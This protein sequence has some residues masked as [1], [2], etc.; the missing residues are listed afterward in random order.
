MFDSPPRILEDP[1]AVPLIGPQGISFIRETADQWQSPGARALRSHVVLRSRFAEDRLAVAAQRGVRQYIVLGAGF[2]TFA[3]RQP[4]WASALQIVEIDHAGTQS[5]KHSMLQAAGIAIPPNV[6]LVS[7]DFEH[8]TLRD[9]LRRHA[10]SHE[11]P[12]FVSWLGVTMYLTEAAIDGVLGTI[13]RFPPGSEVVLTFAPKPTAERS[14][15]ENVGGQTLAEMAA[16]M[17]E[18]WLSFFDTES[19]GSKLRG[20][21]FST[22]Y[23]LTPSEAESLYYR[24]RS[25][26]LPVPKRTS[27]AS[28]IR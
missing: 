18:P 4:D 1:L 9:G 14:P 17:G 25:D 13:A 5:T 2:D 23:Y 16:A 11:E 19:L 26:G 20:A 3:Y 10:I 21:G 28:A 7:I 27:I 6:R 24:N 8:E 15:E 22:I 12:T